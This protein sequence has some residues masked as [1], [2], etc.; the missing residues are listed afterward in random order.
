MRITLVRH[1]E[2]EQNRDGIY[3]GQTDGQLT[4]K[5]IEQAKALSRHFKG[6]HFDRFLASDL[7]RASDTAGYI[8]EVVDTV[9]VEFSE[10]LRERGL[11]IAEGQ[12]KINYPDKSKIEG[13]ETEQQVDDRSQAVLD[14]LLEDQ[15][16]TEILIVAHGGI[17]RSWIRI[18]LKES[19]AVE[20]FGNGSITI[21]SQTDEGW[22]AE[23]L[24]SINHLSDEN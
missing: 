22:E 13:A 11:G 5:G 14:G 6:Q 1:G 16:N 23:A 2:T 20:K 7:A 9:R 17:I 21:L 19:P 24:N 8:H 15:E 12:P 3:M 18:T 4:E 10:L